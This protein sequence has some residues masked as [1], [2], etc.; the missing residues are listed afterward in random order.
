MRDGLGLVGVAV[1]SV[2]CCAGLPLLVAAGVS[3]VAL[4]WIGGLPAALAALAIVVAI[5]VVR[6]RKVASARPADHR[7][8]EAGR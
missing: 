5:L 8:A 6:A 2:V 3:A 4:A 7:R 1:L